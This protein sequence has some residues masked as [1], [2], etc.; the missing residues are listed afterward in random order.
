M[1]KECGMEYSFVFGV[2]FHK[3][4]CSQA[5]QAFKLRALNLGTEYLGSGKHNQTVVVATD[6]KW[7]HK[8]WI[9]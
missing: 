5:K 3:A 2:Q 7:E 8:K 1:C 6:K 9:T 4:D